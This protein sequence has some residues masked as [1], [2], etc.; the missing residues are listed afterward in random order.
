MDS[1]PVRDA[2]SICNSNIVAIFMGSF[3]FAPLDKQ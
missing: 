1:L 2:M 3:F